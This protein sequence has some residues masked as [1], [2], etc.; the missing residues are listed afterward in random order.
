MILLAN[1]EGHDQTG[2]Q[3]DL[4]LRYPH[5]PEGTFLTARPISCIIRII[6]VNIVTLDI[7]NYY[8]IVLKSLCSKERKKERER[9]E[10]T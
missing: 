8:I 6:A 5:M 3:V 1:S 9:R 7:P 2:S 10:E 4:C